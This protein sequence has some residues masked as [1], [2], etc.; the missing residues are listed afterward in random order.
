MQLSW[1]THAEAHRHSDSLFPPMSWATAQATL[2]PYD[3][4]FVTLAKALAADL[5]HVSDPKHP[6]PG[7][8][9]RYRR[10]LIEVKVAL[11]A[12]PDVPNEQGVSF[13]LSVSRTPAVPLLGRIGSSKYT[14]LRRFTV[15]EL[16]ARSA[17]VLSALHAAVGVS[18]AASEA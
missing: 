2:A 6:R 12:E 8:F 15:A 7:Q 4:E 16:Q 3:E 17:H 9:L 10:G 13:I 11:W 5:T 1:P 14:E 18:A